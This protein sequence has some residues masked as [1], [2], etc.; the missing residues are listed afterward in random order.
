MKFLK[1]FK[2]VWII[3]FTALRALKKGHLQKCHSG[4]EERALS[5]LFWTVFMLTNTLTTKTEALLIKS[6]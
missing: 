5:G 6:Q 2:K 4:G 3:G 1:A